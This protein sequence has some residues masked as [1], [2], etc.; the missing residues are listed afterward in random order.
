MP[1]TDQPGFRATPAWAA[2][3]AVWAVWPRDLAARSELAEALR[4]I[5]EPVELLVRPPDMRDATDRLE[6]TPARFHELDTDDA[7]VRAAAPIFVARPGEVAAAR[8]AGTPMAA[9]ICELAEARELRHDLVVDGRAI[10]V[11]GAGTALAT[12]QWLLGA[13]N[14]GLDAR[15]V[16]GLLHRAID[17]ESV[18]WLDRGLGDGLVTE[19]ARFV[20]PGVVVCMETVAG[21]P[22]RDVLREVVASLHT[23]RDATGRRLEVF[24][25]PAPFGARG[26]SYLT[27][28]V[29]ASAVIVPQF[30]A[31]ADDRALARL[32]ELFPGRALRPLPARA[33]LGLG[34]FHGCV[35]GQPTRC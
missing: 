14:P 17:A 31:P 26:A 34:G 27:F 29:A 7:P 32:A 23:A 16:A 22:D 2:K 30:G 5:A 8:F 15:E 10:D 33:L 28:Y 35:L 12:R 18:G 19:V 4:A 25:I 11:D 1:N 3:S 20:A 21:D 13:R 9:A 24:T 6:G